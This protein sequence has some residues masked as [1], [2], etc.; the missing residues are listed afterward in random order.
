MSGSVLPRTGQKS[1]RF[2]E[3][4]AYRGI[5]A[6][7]L[8]I[9]HFYASVGNF[10]PPAAPLTDAIVGGLRLSGW[11]F[12]LSGFLLF[13]L[14]ACAAVAGDAAPCWYTFL[15]RR[16]QRIIPPYY[17]ALVTLWL[18]AYRPD[19]AHWRDLA[20]H[21]GFL[22]SFDAA[23]TH[24]IISPAWTLSLEALFYVGLAICGPLL[25]SVCGRYST[26]A[27]RQALLIA[28][29]LVAGG[30]SIVYKWQAMSADVTPAQSAVY[31]GI[32][33][34]LDCFV[35]GMLLAVAVANQRISCGPRTARG[36][37]AAGPLGFLA[38]C[39]LYDRSAVVALYYHVLA[40]GAFTL[41]LAATVLAR[42]RPTWLR[43]LNGPLPRG[44]GAI[45]FSLFLW[46]DAVL[47][48]LTNVLIAHRLPIGGFS[49]MALGLT[50]SLLV[51]TL[52]YLLIER[53]F[54]RLGSTRPATPQSRPTS[55][56]APLVTSA[57]IVAPNMAP[58]ALAMNV[59]GDD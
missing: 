47:T 49:Y 36:L 35:L 59:G 31:N 44:L 38:L 46:H 9:F 4:S 10:A 40:S 21:L 57:L 1:P 50:L 28:P 22:H 43:H 29:L 5:A 58:V 34:N 6:L 12:T 33:A 30:G 7:L 51:G 56:L 14:F 53:P 13:L 20:L 17:V 8:V 24:S 48:M 3:V 26:V 15:R 39:L 37:L 19:S 18:L 54:L 42:V 52:G 32:L 45:S 2:E 25:C 41:I 23:T 55:A 11:F 16:A 27:T